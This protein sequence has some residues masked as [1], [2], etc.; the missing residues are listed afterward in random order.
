MS[1]SRDALFLKFASTYW[2][3]ASTTPLL[4]LPTVGI[5]TFLNIDVSSSLRPSGPTFQEL[6][7]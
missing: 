5:A 3:P 4:D 6:D 2:K 1:A 7:I